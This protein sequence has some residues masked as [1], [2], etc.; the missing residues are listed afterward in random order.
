MAL[1]PIKDDNDLTSISFQYVTVGMIVACVAVFL[2]QQSLGT[3]QGKAILGLG[4]IPAVLFGSRELSSDLVLFPP[5]I[6]LLSSIFLHGGWMHLIFNMLFL[7]VFGDN[8]EDSMGHFRYIIFY[9][10]CG[11][12][13]SLSHAVMEPSS[14]VPLV[15]ASGAISGVL[16]GYLVLHPRARLLVLF[17]NII[18]LRLPAII[19]LGGW[20]GLQFLS[21]SSGEESNTA[22]WAHIGGFLAGMILVVPFRRKSV[23]LFDG[24]GRFGPNDPNA[25]NLEERRH[26]QSIFPNTVKLKP[27]R[28]RPLI[29]KKPPTKP[30]DRPQ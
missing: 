1:L 21:L 20:I 8:V 18:P 13:A 25:I 4:I 30:W 27:D 17:M 29:T 7:W 16:G 3:E 6:T 9:L 19:V 2:W 15:G 26:G 5:T 23:P 28:D 10:I 22:W 11:I 14:A 24:A 12:L